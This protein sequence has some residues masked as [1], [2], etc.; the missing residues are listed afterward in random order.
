MDTPALAGRDKLKFECLLLREGRSVLRH[1]VRR[2]WFSTPASSVLG[3]GC[4]LG[5]CNTA[6]YQSFLVFHD[7]CFS[8]TRSFRSE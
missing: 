3:V 7:T 8:V 2:V 1:Y 4:D 6:K 5:F